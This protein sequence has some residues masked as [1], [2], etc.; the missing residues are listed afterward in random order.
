MT[1]IS[2]KENVSPDGES[3]APPSDRSDRSSGG[4]LPLGGGHLPLGGGHLPLGS[5]HLPLSSG[6]LPLALG[7]GH[8]PLSGGRLVNEVATRLQHNDSGVGVHVVKENGSEIKHASDINEQAMLPVVPNA[9]NIQVN[10]GPPGDMIIG[11]SAP[12]DN[13]YWHVSWYQLLICWTSDFI[14]ASVVNGMSVGASRLCIGMPVS[15]SC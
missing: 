6:H 1:I 10:G 7:G 3:T 8:L 5:G 2:D 9:R 4:H 14:L 13:I 12:V 15:S 11:Q